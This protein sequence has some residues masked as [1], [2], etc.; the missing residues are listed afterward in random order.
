M[1]TVDSALVRY[2]IRALGLTDWTIKVRLK[3]K[4]D[5]FGARDRSGEAEYQTVI[6]CAAI[7]VIDGSCFTPR[8]RAFDEEQVLVHELL[9]L[10]FALIYPENEGTRATATHQL[11]DEMAWAL[12]RAR[13][14]E[15]H[16][17]D[18]N[19]DEKDT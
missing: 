6:K 8:V 3:C 13:R 19:R 18:K 17:R 16:D 11:I 10:K 4:P 5:E 15:S 7:R 14:T 2:W 12:V 1:Q 9:H